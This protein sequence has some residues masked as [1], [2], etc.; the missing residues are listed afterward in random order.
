MRN[1]FTYAYL[2]RL[3]APWTQA[4]SPKIDASR[5]RIDL[6]RQMAAGAQIASVSDIGMTEQD[7]I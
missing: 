6:P 4:E 5:Q 1:Q 7:P 2:L 3:L